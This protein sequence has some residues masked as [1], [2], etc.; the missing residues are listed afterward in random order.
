VFRSCGFLGPGRQDQTRFF[1]LD[2]QHKV[3]GSNA[4]NFNLFPLDLSRVRFSSS[5][6]S[7]SSIIQ[8][9]LRLEITLSSPALPSTWYLG[10]PPPPPDHY[11]NYICLLVA[12]VIFEHGAEAKFVGVDKSASTPRRFETRFI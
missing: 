5:S 9:P 6:S 4:G 7:S 10:K 12:V 11:N 1:N 8:N 3:V 2:K